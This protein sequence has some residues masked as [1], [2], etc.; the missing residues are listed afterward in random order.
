MLV[1][2]FLGAGQY[3]RATDLQGP[4]TATISHVVEEQVGAED[5]REAKLVMHFMK[6]QKGLVLNQTNLQA[7]AA[8]YGDETDAWTGKRI[9]LYVDPNVFF[10]GKKIGGLRLRAPAPAPA[11]AKQALAPAAPPVPVEEERVPGV[12]EDCPF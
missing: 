6:G 9:E 3:L 1:S 8:L 12:D 4:I 5:E 10:S 2:K 11:K 7:C